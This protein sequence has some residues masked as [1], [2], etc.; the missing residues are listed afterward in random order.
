MSGRSAAVQ[1]CDVSKVFARTRSSGGRSFLE[2][3]VELLKR[4]RT[5]Q[6]TFAALQNVSFTL[7][8][9][10]TYGFIGAN[11]AGKSTALK[12]VSGIIEPTAG[13]I[14]TE[15]QIGALLELG[16]GFHPD[17]TGRENV[18]LNGAV[19]GLDRAYMRHHF[20]EIVAFAE[21]EDF[22]DAPV[23]HYSSGMYVRLGFS[24]AIHT[25]PEILLVDEVLAV[26]D[27]SFQQ[28][29]LESIVR[30]RE[31]GV[32]IVIVSHNA[33]SIQAL[34]DEVLWFDHGILAEQGKTTDVVMS[35]MRTVAE[36]SI[37]QSVRSTGAGPVSGR[38]GTRAV[39]IVKVEFVD[40]AGALAEIAV[41]GQPLEIRLHYEAHEP[42]R[43]P[44]F[45]IGIH[46][47]NGIHLTGPNS[48]LDG[49][50]IDSLGPRGVIVYRVPFLP[51][52][53]GLYQL[54]VAIHDRSDA[55]MYDYHDRLHPFFVLPGA[56]QER[57]G[58]LTLNGRWDHRREKRGDA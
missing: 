50:A 17:L 26:G 15:G 7:E 39:E 44:V 21:L 10:K 19:L 42:I 46:T 22:I 34:C 53:E 31:Q 32:T 56:S 37:R 52:L 55:V 36:K 29:C 4:E 40:R 13:T 41:T 58:L 48:L 2:S 51:L 20:D 18:F 54:S 1:F 57:H 25:N 27:A 24:V 14:T 3:F 45:G 38:W 8:K 47:H 16:A 49:Y 6:R 33:A 23:K 35:Y 28:K 11:G 12:L 5:T 9:G 43:D 30:L